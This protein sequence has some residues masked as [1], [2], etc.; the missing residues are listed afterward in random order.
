MRV[1]VAASRVSQPVEARRWVLE[2]SNQVF[3]AWERWLQK[4]ESAWGE[5]FLFFEPTLPIPKFGRPNSHN[6]VDLL[7][8]F[9]DRLALFEVKSDRERRTLRLPKI[10]DQINGQ[11]AWLQGLLNDGNYGVT[12]GSFSKYLFLSRQSHAAAEELRREL[13]ERHSAPH[14]LPLGAA[15]PTQFM[16]HFVARHWPRLSVPAGGSGLQEFLNDRMI[17]AGAHFLQFDSLSETSAYLKTVLPTSR[18]LPEEWYVPA[19]RSAELSLAHSLLLKNGMVEVV[20][21]PGI[22]KSTLVM[23]LSNR[24][25]VEILPVSL[26]GIAT[27]RDVG[28]VIYAALRCEPAEELSEQVIRRA[29]LSEPHMFWIAECGECSTDALESFLTQLR[30]EA[31]ANTSSTSLWVIES[32]NPRPSL[33]GSRV[34]LAPLSREAVSTMLP[35]V[36]TE[37]HDLEPERVA[38][39]ALGNPGRA[40]RL[41]QLGESGDTADGRKWFTWRMKPL[42]RDILRLLAIAANASPFGCT[43]DVIAQWACAMYGYTT[44]ESRNSTDELLRR[45]HSQQL[46]RVIRV[47]RS[48]FEGLLNDIIP[49]DATLTIVRDVSRE[50]L[51]YSAPN[52]HD[53]AVLVDKLQEVLFHCASDS[54]HRATASEI[55]LGFLQG[56]LS[57]FVESSFRSTSLTQTLAWIEREQWQPRMSQIPVLR[58]LRIL[59]HV[60]AGKIDNE[61]LTPAAGDQIQQRVCRVI[62]ARTKSRRIDV[63]APLE[64]L[65]AEV[66]VTRDD[67]EIQAESLVGIANAIESATDRDRRL[68]HHDAWQVLNGLHERYS[69]E[70]AAWC[71]SVVQ[72]LAFLNREKSRRGVLNESEASEL[73]QSLSRKCIEFGIAHGN[74]QMICDGLFYI[75]RLSERSSAPTSTKVTGYRSALSFIDGAQ[76]RPSRRLQVL[77]TLGS[78]HRHFCAQH[79]V[80]WS[81][82]RQHMQDALAAYQRVLRSGK[83][84]G[85]V[86]YVLISLSCTMDLCLKACRLAS[87]EDDASFVIDQCA[88]TIRSANQVEDLLS[89]RVVGWEGENTFTSVRLAYPLVLYVASLVDHDPHA[90]GELM[91]HLK[92][93]AS[94][95][96]VLVRNR[97]SLEASKLTRLLLGRL[98]RILEFE[99]RFFSRSPTLQSMHGGI[100]A[101]LF[102]TA[103]ICA[104][105]KTVSL[106]CRILK[107]WAIAGLTHYSKQSKDLERII[108]SVVELAHRAGIGKKELENLIHA[109]SIG[110]IDSVSA[111]EDFSSQLDRLFARAVRSAFDP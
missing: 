36:P 87:N 43:A 25:D 2:L 14:I 90:A 85:R 88:S 12:P 28:R 89:N 104:G 100:Q 16:N 64:Q 101:I 106:W 52:E 66:K 77:L 75:C 35:R 30:R 83:V 84:Y 48:V 21:P 79:G 27:S 91:E 53:R 94:D 40:I 73:I 109:K 23:E 110:I 17:A 92:A 80:G 29:L 76:G 78:V 62:E 15:D 44:C 22:G 26:K 8:A 63:R 51:N 18:I 5:C 111:A 54:P 105:L 99:Q 11:I 42:E 1:L 3:R 103:G 46:A 93:C 71:I 74:L 10:V 68:R 70:S 107:C 102:S 37:Q 59:R 49:Q 81:M 65:L 60:C 95:V 98:A 56:S 9:N 19:L 97:G 72:Q 31:R 39:L 58:Y 55:A 41:W 20:G 6:Q 7:L 47:D 24:F 96:R 61:L 67:P 69:P 45:L 57:D 32:T 82:F 4:Q 86:D 13:I 33:M 34:E 38:D 108:A 50:L